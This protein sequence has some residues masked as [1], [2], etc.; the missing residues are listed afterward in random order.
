MYRHILVTLDGS[1]MGESALPHVEAI[2]RACLPDGR[3]TLLQ[4]VTPLHLYEGLEVS[5]PP[6][7]K[8]R[9]ENEATARVWEYLQ[10]V[11]DRLDTGDVA[12]DIEVCHG[13]VAKEVVAYANRT[14]ADLIVIGSHGHSEFR[15][16]IIGSVA[17]KVTRNACTPIFLVPPP[18]CRI[19]H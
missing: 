7:E 17:N 12:V 16:L 8:E 3:I 14:E 4:V 5:L 13:D 1:E 18:Q 6:H 2:S 9:L 11:A 10:A 15:H 19:K